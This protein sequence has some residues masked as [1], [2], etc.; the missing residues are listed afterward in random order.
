M[1]NSS[2]GKGWIPMPVFVFVVLLA[3]WLALKKGLAGWRARK[4]PT[5]L[6]KISLLLAVM[7]NL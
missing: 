7:R 4:A 3:V 6:V 2:N 5:Y 1:Q